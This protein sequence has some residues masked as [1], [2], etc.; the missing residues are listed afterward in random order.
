[1]NIDLTCL[2]DVRDLADDIRLRADALMER[3][4]AMPEDRLADL[5]AVMSGSALATKS[6]RDGLDA[7]RNA[8]KERRPCASR[9]H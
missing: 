7:V 2:R 3:S 1:M 4:S 6:I 9:R 8:R 5:I